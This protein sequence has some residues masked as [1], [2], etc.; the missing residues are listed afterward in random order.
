VR[1]VRYRLASAIAARSPEQVAAFIDEQTRIET[2]LV[3]IVVST[4]LLIFV[5][6]LTLSIER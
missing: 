5:T 4:F 1:G 2:R 3:R 6:A